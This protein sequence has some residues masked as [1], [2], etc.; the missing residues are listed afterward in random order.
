MADSI[1]LKPVKHRQQQSSY[2][3]RKPADDIRLRCRVRIA[4]LYKNSHYSQRMKPS[5]HMS[6]QSAII[7]SFQVLT[8]PSDQYAARYSV[9]PLVHLQHHA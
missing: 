9:H 7:S 4:E 3:L 2:F 1:W 6:A 8:L 5:G